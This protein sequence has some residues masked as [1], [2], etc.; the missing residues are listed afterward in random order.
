MYD[1]FWIII[2]VVSLFTQYVLKVQY[3]NTLT[4][5]FASCIFQT[6]MTRKMS[7]SLAIDPVGTDNKLGYLSY[8]HLRIKLIM[9]EYSAGRNLYLVIHILSGNLRCLNVTIG[10]K[11]T[12]S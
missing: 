4:H 12:F 8:D 9:T 3:V 11:R 5:H 2:L 7:T 6:L 1:A 10:C